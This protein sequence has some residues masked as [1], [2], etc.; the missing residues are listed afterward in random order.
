MVFMIFYYRNQDMGG[1][2][3]YC[4]CTWI[5]VEDKLIQALKAENQRL[6]LLLAQ[7]RAAPPATNPCNSADLEKYKLEVEILRHRLQSICGVHANAVAHIR[8]LESHIRMT[9]PLNLGPIYIDPTQIG[10]YTYTA[11]NGQTFSGPVCN[12]CSVL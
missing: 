12:C 3:M 8:N 4:Q 10:T 7:C 6:T 5:S 11:S 9:N 1:P 2:K